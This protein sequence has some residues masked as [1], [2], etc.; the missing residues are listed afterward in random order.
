MHKA[1]AQGLCTS[2]IHK[3]YTQDLYT[4]SIYKVYAVVKLKKPSI[5]IIA[6]K[7]FIA[8]IGKNIPL[9]IQRESLFSLMKK[10]L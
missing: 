7:Y 8:I 2:L 5:S 3:A 10:A 6:I 1:Y 9:M 4:R